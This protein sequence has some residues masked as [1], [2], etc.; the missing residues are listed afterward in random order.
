MPPVSFLGRGGQGRILRM[1][2]IFSYSNIFINILRWKVLDN[3]IN[4]YFIKYGGIAM[5]LSDMGEQIF[6]AQ[7]ILK[8]RIRKVRQNCT[9]AQ[10]HF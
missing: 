8:Q 9:L 6:A 5:E 10:R 2:K 4:A 1:V 3:L 7:R